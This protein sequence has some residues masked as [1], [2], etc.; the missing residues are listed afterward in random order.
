MNVYGTAPSAKVYLVKHRPRLVCLRKHRSPNPSMGNDS[1]ATLDGSGT[2]AISP[3]SVIVPV[4][5]LAC[6]VEFPVQISEIVPVNGTANPRTSDAETF[7]V[8]LEF[9]LKAGDAGAPFRVK[10]LIFRGANS[11]PVAVLPAPVVLAEG[12]VKFTIRPTRPDKDGKLAQP[13]PEQEA[14]D[15]VKP[16]PE[17]TPLV[18]RPLSKVPPAKLIVI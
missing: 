16:I 15:A 13:I 17:S 3:F 2:A 18:V 5:T 9:A 1:S 7:S 11:V 10:A 14:D 6:A 8:K 4:A 12:T